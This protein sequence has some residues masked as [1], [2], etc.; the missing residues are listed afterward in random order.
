MK[1][2]QTLKSI[3]DRI[4]DPNS[5]LTPVPEVRRALEAKGYRYELNTI[6]A[7]SMGRPGVAFWHS[8][9]TADGKPIDCWDRKDAASVQYFKDYTEAVAN[10]KAAKIAAAPGRGPSL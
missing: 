4:T 2:L 6:M 8:V 5:P 10:Y 7:P 9:M 3:W 1:V